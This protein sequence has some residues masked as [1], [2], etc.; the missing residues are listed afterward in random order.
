MPI[1]RREPDG[2][3]LKFAQR[4]EGGLET[5]SVILPQRGRTGRIRTSLCEPSSSWARWAV[6]FAKP[7][8]WA[9]ESNSLQTRSGQ[10]FAAR[11]SEQQT[12]TNIV[13]MGMGEPTDNIK[14]VLQAIRVL[15]D[16]GGPAI[17][18]SRISVSTVGRA[19]H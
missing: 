15:T 19:G 5:E 2:S 9:E 18:P 3:T 16:H 12:I 7:R 13:F 4:L 6:D 10:W 17:A 11:H 1:V 8:P 14:E